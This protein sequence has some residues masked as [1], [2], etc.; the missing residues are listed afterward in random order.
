MLPAGS[1][2]TT[3][4]LNF[5]ANKNF[6]RSDAMYII[7]AYCA[8]F[9][10]IFMI[11]NKVYHS[12]GMLHRL[13]RACERTPG[14]TCST[15]SVVGGN[16]LEKECTSADFDSFLKIATVRIINENKGDALMQFCKLYH[17]LDTAIANQGF[18]GSGTEINIKGKKTKIPKVSSLCESSWLNSGLVFAFSQYPFMQRFFDSLTSQVAKFAVTIETPF[19]PTEI[20]T[21]D[22]ITAVVDRLNDIC[23]GLEAVLHRL[24]FHL[25]RETALPLF[26]FSCNVAP[27]GPGSAGRLAIDMVESQLFHHQAVQAGYVFDSLG[28]SDEYGRDANNSGDDSG[29]QQT[30]APLSTTATTTVNSSSGSSTIAQEL[31]KAMTE[32]LGPYPVNM[33]YIPL[34]NNIFYAEATT[35]QQQQQQQQYSYLHWFLQYCH[36]NLC[37]KNPASETRVHNI[38]LL[39]VLGG[40]LADR[41]RIQQNHRRLDIFCRSQ[42]GNQSLCSVLP[43]SVLKD[44][45]SCLEEF[46]ATSTKATDTNRRA[47]HTTTSDRNPI[48][49]DSS[50]SRPVSVSIVSVEQETRRSKRIRTL[51][52][53]S[54]ITYASNGTHNSSSNSNS[55]KSSESSKSSNKIDDFVM[56]AFSQADHL[57]ALYGTALISKD[58]IIG[59]L[60]ALQQ[61]EQSYRE[62]L[63]DRDYDSL[64]RA[65]T[66]CATMSSSS[67]GSLV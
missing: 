18:E 12:I 25:H 35:Q 50:S 54:S 56:C 17:D 51:Q 47:I 57:I 22:S 20:M 4:P 61:H 66:A 42:V 49:I 9:Q 14:W 48:A 43:L 31:L 36:R 44:I 5:I 11:F 67:S 33:A 29:S 46:V 64:V 23:P 40:F 15:D 39:T 37:P 45:F 19:G 58:T 62:L 52:S 8:I 34:L 16:I 38:G 26:Y 6:E 7:K 28:V 63:E 1:P 60:Q 53:D 10:L 30:A 27:G 55:S 65:C 41:S 13:F 2:G 24:Q 32:Q 21:D 59:L 3:A